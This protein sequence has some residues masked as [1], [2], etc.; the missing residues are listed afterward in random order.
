MRGE[1]LEEDLSVVERPQPWSIDI[2]RRSS[3]IGGQRT[4][5]VDSP[6][7]SGVGPLATIRL[8][9]TRAAMSL[10]LDPSSPGQVERK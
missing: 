6:Q 3:L 8:A 9:P 4:E 5:R 1:G 2:R 7:E 10:S